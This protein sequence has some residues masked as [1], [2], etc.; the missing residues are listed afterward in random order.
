MLLLSGMIIGVGM[1][2]IPFSFVAAGF[3]LGV[4]ELAVLS[5]VVTA[6]HLL[7]GE[8]ILATSR[9]HRMPGYIRIYLGNGA[10]T[11]SWVSTLFG[12]TGTLLAYLVAGSL[13]LQNIFGSGIAGAKSLVWVVVLVLGGALITFFPLKKEAAMNGVLAFFEI[14][15]MVLLVALLFP[16]ISVAHFLGIHREN[17]FLPYGVLL[18]ALS[19]GS[20]IPD[21]V[22]VLG[23]DKKRVRAAI[24]IGSTIPAML[25]FLFA[26]AVVGVSGNATSTEAIAGL[27]RVIGGNIG[28]WAS[29]AGLLAILTSFITL[30]ASFQALLFLDMRIPRPLAW[31]SASAIP[32]A[33]YL[34]GF[35]NF[36][37]IIGVVGIVAFGIDAVLFLLMG[38]Q[39][40][41]RF[42]RSPLSAFTAYTILMVIVIGVA[43]ELYRM[44]APL[45]LR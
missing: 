35:Q 41:K 11:V 6:L 3:W 1:F 24:I 23:R 5:C 19:G 17:F 42:G 30:S 15:F 28:L 34:A 20:V 38:W 26:L 33:L 18:F 21:L 22:T 37:A 40:K 45:P 31:I 44:I 14:G 10:T 27:E 8:V 32:F 25:Y 36:I 2:A 13:F 16:K 4:A 12:I 39:I 29:A 7:Y 43:A 9:F